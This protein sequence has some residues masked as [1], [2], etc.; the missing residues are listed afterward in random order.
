MNDFLLH[1]GQKFYCPECGA[2]H[3]A[4]DVPYGTSMYLACLSEPYDYWQNTGKKFRPHVIILLL[5]YDYENYPS[6]L[7]YFR[8]I[9][10]SKDYSGFAWELAGLDK[11]FYPCYTDGEFEKLF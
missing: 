6:S 4:P 3:Y 2:I 11:E 9:K 5:Q 7:E 1:L 10:E 8:S